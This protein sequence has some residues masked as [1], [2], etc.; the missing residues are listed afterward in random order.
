[1][2]DSST[3][4]IYCSVESIFLSCNLILD[5]SHLR[6]VIN[7]VLIEHKTGIVQILL[8]RVYRTCKEVVKAD[9]TAIFLR[10]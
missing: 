5:Y 1:M 7:I 8:N 6:K 4:D 3:I 10:F 9:N 2:Y